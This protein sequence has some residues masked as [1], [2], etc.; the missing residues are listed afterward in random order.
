M[1]QK[2]AYDWPLMMQSRSMSSMFKEEKNFSKHLFQEL[3]KNG[4]I[5]KVCVLKKS[6]PSPAS[7]QRGGIDNNACRLTYSQINYTSI[8]YVL[9]WL[10]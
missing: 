3:S 7:S 4:V 5:A 10:Q 8:Y 6:I 9:E 2:W 1:K